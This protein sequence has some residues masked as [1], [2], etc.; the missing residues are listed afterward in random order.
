MKRGG[1][2]SYGPDEALKRAR[3]RGEDVSR[4]HLF[5]TAG[6]VADG[7]WLPVLAVLAADL[8][9]LALIITVIAAL[10]AP[11]IAG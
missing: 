8:L 3:E 11:R 9:T 2:D 5:G 7:F 4:G 10:I 1:Y 6:A